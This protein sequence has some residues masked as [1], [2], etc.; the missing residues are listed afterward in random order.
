[1]IHGMFEYIERYLPF[2][3]YLTTKGF[4]VIGHDHLGH[5]QSINT[6][7]DL[8]YF[9]KP[10]PNELVIHDIHTLRLIIQ[11]KYP[12]CPIFMAGH[13]MCSYL[14]REYILQKGEG[15]AGAVIIGTGYE[16]CF[17]TTMG[18]LLCKF[19]KCF[20]GSRHRSKCIKKK[21]V[22]RRAI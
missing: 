16:S 7:D 20:K 19:I 17:T 13:S 22:R 15:I 9:G 4:L 8:G 5:G 6:K 3:E 1:M 2:F 21:D 18:L 10:R 12:N 14:L 11:Y